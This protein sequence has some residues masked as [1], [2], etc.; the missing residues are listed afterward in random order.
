MM[1]AI[2]RV[3]TSKSQIAKVTRVTPRGLPHGLQIT[4]S[5]FGG[6]NILLNALI[7]HE[8]STMVSS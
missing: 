8:L 5:K 4:A 3:M 1:K 2:A 7:V 6:Y